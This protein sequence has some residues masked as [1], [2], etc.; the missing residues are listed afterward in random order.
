MFNKVRSTILCCY[1]IRLIF[2]TVLTVLFP[3]GSYALENP[4]PDAAA[5]MRVELFELKSDA[6]DAMVPMSVLLPPEFDRETETQLPLLIW[7]HGGGGDRHQLVQ[8][9]R[10]IDEFLDQNV[11]PPM[12]FVSFSTSAF[13]GY[14]GTWETFIEDELPVA[15]ASRYH[16]RTDRDGV[17]IGGISMGGYGA[18]KSAFRN[19][20]RYLAVGAMEPS[21]E[22][23]LTELP[24][25]TRNTWTRGPAPALQPTD[26]PARQVHDNAAAIRNSNLNIYLECGDEDYLN[27]HDGAEFLHRVLW[28]NDIRH[29]YHLVRW[30]D[31]VGGSMTG[32]L[33]EMLA[34]F[35]QSLAG[36]RVD[37]VA[38]PI[39]EGEQ[40][41]LTQV[42]ERAARGEAPPPEFSE[43]LYG[44]RGPTLH[45]HAWGSLKVL[46]DKDPAMKRNYAELP[47]TSL[48]VK[49]SD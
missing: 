41:L 14:L 22:P 2:I 11:I 37:P 32:R 26:N 48:P 49:D 25:F 44:P 38:L 1:V 36:G 29:E 13:S 30:A 28:D 45:A 34:F 4:I 47:S 19:P 3:H 46:A 39:N 15:M 27:L 23:T 24:N 6:V 20:T 42:G 5:G 8:L 43:Y 7:L 10:Y 21:I 16:T 17:M 33:R 40:E 12:V 31:H 9:K 35:A 18:L